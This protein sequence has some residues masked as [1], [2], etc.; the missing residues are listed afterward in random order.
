LEK[1]KTPK[2]ETPVA[3]TNTKTPVEKLLDDL[4]KAL[5]KS[6][7]RQQKLTVGIKVLSKMKNTPVDEFGEA[8]TAEY[9]K[10]VIDK[11]KKILSEN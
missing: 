11:C 4:S 5:D 7:K 9:K 10:S 2:Q 6:V 1:K 8:L 3:P